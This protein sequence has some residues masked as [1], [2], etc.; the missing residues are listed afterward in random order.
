MYSAEELHRRDALRAH[1]ERIGV[2]SLPE[3][4]CSDYE[5]AGEGAGSETEAE[6]HPA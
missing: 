3:E 5:E 2:H 1:Y 4:S 6:E